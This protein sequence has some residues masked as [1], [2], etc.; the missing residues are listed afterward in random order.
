VKFK[1]V[2]GEST[3]DLVTQEA[4]GSVDY[5]VNGTSQISGQASLVPISPGVY[6]VLL[7]SKSITVNVSK[8]EG[9]YEAVSASGR[10]FLTI[11]DKRDRAEKQRADAGSGPIEVRAQMP[12][13]IISLLVGPGDEVQAGQSLLVIEAM[14]MQNELKSPKAGRV[15]KLLVTEGETVPANYRLV[16][17]E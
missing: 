3:F 2:A 12:G 4:G 17:I 8:E 15:S 9:Q 13:K 5:A 10:L 14:K 6:S 1:V 11:A 7:G 16:V